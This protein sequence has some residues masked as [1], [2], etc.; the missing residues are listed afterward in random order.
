MKIVVDMDEVLCQFVDE[1]LARWNHTHRTNV[2]RSQ[3]DM[4][5]ME[6]RLGPGAVKFIDDLMNDEA[7]Y[8]NLKPIPGAIDG[9]NELIRL[10]HDIVVATSITPHA[11]HAFDGKRAWMRHYFP[12]WDIRSFIACSRKGLLQGCDV[13]IDDGA[14]NI[15]DWRACGGYRAIVMSAPWNRNVGGSDVVRAIN[16]EHVVQII[17][18]WT[19][20]DKFEETQAEI[21]TTELTRST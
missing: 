14:H 7:F 18:Y 11:E 8:A 13:L 15:E 17:D 21:Y 20:C 3:I 5:H 10:G 16:W 19:T 4:W 9:F 2:M 6:E 1:V 12:Q